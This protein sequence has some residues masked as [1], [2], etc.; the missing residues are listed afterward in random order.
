MLELSESCV[1]VCAKQGP[2]NSGF[3]AVIDVKSFGVFRGQVADGALT[4]LRFEHLGVAAVLQAVA[5][6][7]AVVRVALGVILS[8]RLAGSAV[9]GG[10]FMAAGRN[11]S[12]RAD[13]T[14]PLLP[15]VLRFVVTKFVERL[16]VL[17]TGAP[18]L[19]F[20]RFPAGV[21][22]VR[23]LGDNYLARAAVAAKTVT[24]RLRHVELT[25]GLGRAA[26]GTGF[27]FDGHDRSPVGRAETITGFRSVSKGILTCSP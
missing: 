8:P 22:A 13:F 4:P 17:T 2:D 3:V 6:L 23:L 10:V 11:S 20:G 7:R 19:S 26:F 15:V 1:A 12:Y 16:R 5:V 25:S 18:L 21:R 24:A 9:R 14:P 27:F